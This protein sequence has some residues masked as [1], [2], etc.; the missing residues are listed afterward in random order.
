[1]QLYPGQHFYV[2]AVLEPGRE[3]Y[4]EWFDCFDNQLQATIEN[5]T[6]SASIKQ[7]V[8]DHAWQYYYCGD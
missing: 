1:M 5:S 7:Y 3:Y 2:D 6:E 8:C 4:Q